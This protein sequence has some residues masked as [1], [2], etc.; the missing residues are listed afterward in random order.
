MKECR[1]EAVRENRAAGVVGVGT[2]VSKNKQKDLSLGAALPSDIR[3]FDIGTL[4]GSILV[5]NLARSQAL[6]VW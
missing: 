2:D 4:L 5:K 3:H 1:M 6:V